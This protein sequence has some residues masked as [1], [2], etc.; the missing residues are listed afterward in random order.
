AQRIAGSNRYETAAL[1]AEQRGIQDAIFLANGSAWADSLA[2]APLARL[3]GGSLL[4]TRHDSTPAVTIGAIQT[5]DAARIVALGGSSQIS[6]A[7][8]NDLRNR[9]Y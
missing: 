3:Q 1:V 7:Q 2:G 6:E 4:L 5:A 8:L 9:G